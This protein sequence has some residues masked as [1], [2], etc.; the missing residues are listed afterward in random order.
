M[1]DITDALMKALKPIISRVRTDVTAIK[2]DGKIAWTREPLTE[3]RLKQHLLNG[4]SRGV[5]PIKEKE[6]VTRVAVLDMDSHKG[7][8]PW[9]TMAQEAEKVIA[10]LKKYSVMAI[11]FRSSG[12]HGIHLFVLWDE[13][14]DA[15][16]VR[17]FLNAAILTVGY[18]NG[19]GGVGKKEIEIFPKQNSVPE[20]GFGNQFF[21]P[22]AGKS[23]PL[24]PIFDLDLMD[25]GYAAKMKWP[26]S[27]PVVFVKQ[28]ALRTKN[29]LMGGPRRPI[30]DHSLHAESPE[31][32]LEALKHV[33]NDVDYDEW[34][35]IL[36]ALKGALGG[37][38]KYYPEIEAWA[39]QWPDN[40]P[41]IVRKKWDSIKE[42][43]A[44]AGTIFYYAQKAGWVHP[45]T[46]TPEWLETMND[47]YFVVMDGGKAVIYSEQYD[48]MTQRYNLVSSSFEDIRNLCKNE[49]V[50]IGDKFVSKGRAWIEHRRRRTYK[51][52]V[53][54]APNKQ[55]RP[56]QYNL[57]RGYGVEPQKGDWQL[58]RLH[59]L[60]IIC[61]GDHKLYDYVIKWLARS[62][63]QPAQ[64][65]MVALVLQGGQG[66]GKGF[67]SRY[68][69]RLFG[70]HYLH[71]DNAEHIVGK[72]N[73]HLRDAILIFADE[74]F[75]A[76]DRR[77][78]NKMKSFIT[79][80][81]FMLEDKYMKA[82]KSPNYMHFILASNEHH[83]V[84]VEADDRRHLVLRVSEKVKNDRE[85]FGAL[86]TEM[87]NGGPEAM[88]HDLLSMDLSSFD[89]FDVPKTEALLKQKLKS[90]TGPEAWLKNCLS[91][92]EV[93]FC[94]WTEQGLEIP[95]ST[96]HKNYAENAK[97]Y[98]DL[99][100]QVDPSE[101]GEEIKRKQ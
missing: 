76:G 58:M 94:E 31:L 84:N 65:G 51:G 18:K 60:D 49:A 9:E 42:T 22:L 92:A 32:V 80:N 28:N 61:C 34:I 35:K 47:D 64:P 72:F 52:G 37:N 53:I 89:V 95:R 4:T 36:A 50:M 56:D 24:D 78:K 16:S 11:P 71:V 21:L 48:P 100:S 88:L 85:Y 66:T 67:F 45:G 1:D 55:V 73:G 63:Q 77:I 2:K 59:I 87:D 17:E 3:E 7:E 68:C 99:R 86:E 13:P 8:I 30:G 46:S 83:V 33:K 14:Q 6:N 19:T 10:Q 97:Q 26:V 57:W 69:G 75:F 15:F 54:L 70:Q 90:L 41:E 20:G 74:A 39:L 81:T 38:E 93:S 5:C 101:F 91:Q 44:G 12:G 82:Q 25:K 29:E 40:T 27:A 23:V 43:A 79:E 96:A 62:L 98:G